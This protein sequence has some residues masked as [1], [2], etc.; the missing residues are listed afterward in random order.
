MLADKVT[1]RANIIKR[2]IVELPIY[3]ST[4]FVITYFIFSLQEEPLEEGTN[5]PEITVKNT[6]KPPRVQNG[7]ENP[8]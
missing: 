4:T 2:V 1:I 5:I 8:Q 7:I 6:V 3:N